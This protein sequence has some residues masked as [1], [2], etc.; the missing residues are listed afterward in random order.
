MNLTEALVE[1]QI[2]AFKDA[3][4]AI[5]SLLASVSLLEEAIEGNCNC[6]AVLDDV[7]RNLLDNARRYEVHRFYS[8]W[9]NAAYA[10]E[11]FLQQTKGDKEA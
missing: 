3:H 11:Q 7:R 6:K 9:K 5:R 2:E 8:A 4:R 1:A 10:F